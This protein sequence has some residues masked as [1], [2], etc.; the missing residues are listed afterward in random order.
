MIY[1]FKYL[2][3]IIVAI[4]SIMIFID[5]LLTYFLPEDNSIRKFLLK[6]LKPIYQPIRRFI[7]PLA[8]IDFTP[9]LAI[10]LLQ[11][12]DGVLIYLLS[13]IG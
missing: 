11:I 6:I 4:L 13:L 5:T 7:P 12:L 1:I 10:V 8:G 9:L 2:I 3:N